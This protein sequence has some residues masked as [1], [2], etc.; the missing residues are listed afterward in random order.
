M[1]GVGVSKWNPQHIN[2]LVLIGLSKG[3][4]K[5]KTKI[6]NPEFELQ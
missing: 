2:L 4:G 5:E 1:V 6:W 3:K